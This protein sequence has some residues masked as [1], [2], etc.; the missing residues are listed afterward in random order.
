MTDWL[1]ERAVDLGDLNPGV[2]L[3]LEPMRAALADVRV[4][5]LGEATHGTGEF[6]LLKHVLLRF[7]VT[8]L[9]F[10]VL[11]M[12][13]SA[14]ASKAVDD[15]V[16][17]GVG[18]PAEALAGLGFWTWRTTE[19]LAV[20]EW[21]REHNRTAATKVRFVGIDPQIPGESLRRLDGW[22][23][24]SAPELLAPLAPL[25]DFRLGLHP[26]LGEDVVAGAR[27]LLDFVTAAGTDQADTGAGARADA[28]ARADAR[29]VLQAAEL[30]TR[31]FVHQDPERTISMARDR[32]MADNVDEILRDPAAR[33]AVWA[34]NGHVMRGEHPR[35]GV[36][37]MGRHL[38]E[39]HG[40][41]YYALG[42]LFGE[43]EFRARRHGFLRRVDPDKPPVIAKV[44]PARTPK[45]VEARLAAAG[46]ANYL[47]DLRTGTPPEAVRTWL[48][49]PAY[50]RTFGAVVGRFRYKTT[51]AQTVPAEQFDGLAFVS[52]GTASHPL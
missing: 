15:Y 11:A 27:R 45:V 30:A 46:P 9:G 26:P 17:H 20:L 52:R 1:A 28:D 47:L 34:H 18:D 50:V 31:P 16:V 2:A 7:M 22:F 4:A 33:V 8:E 23:G 39:R 36:T 37:T 25:A 35:A 3:D 32:F 21:L 48:G 41:G 44:P 12:E 42:L 51:F 40:S 6:F 29:T 14:A 5:G 24:E 19:V 43:G 13:A 49:E 38:A 10:N